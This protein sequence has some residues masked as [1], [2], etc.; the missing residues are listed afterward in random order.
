MIAL[1]L[2]VAAAALAIMYGIFGMLAAFDRMAADQAAREDAWTSE[3]DVIAD[4]MRRDGA[5][6]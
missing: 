1:Q 6:Q 4:L 3:L 2:L 5:K